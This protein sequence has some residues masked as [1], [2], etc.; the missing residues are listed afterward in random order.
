M[1]EDRWRGMKEA[2]PLEGGKVGERAAEKWW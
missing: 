1:E 2:V